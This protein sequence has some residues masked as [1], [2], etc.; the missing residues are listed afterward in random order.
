MHKIMEIHG[1][2]SGNDHIN[3][4]NGEKCDFSDFECGVIGGARRSGLSISVTAD[5]LEFYNSC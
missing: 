2:A 4:Q 3:H 5:L 1:A